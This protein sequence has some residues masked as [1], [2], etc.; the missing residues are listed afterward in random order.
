ML[1]AFKEEIVI[2]TIYIKPN[3]KLH[4]IKTHFQEI[5]RFIQYEYSVKKLII[6]GD[7]NVHVLD[8]QNSKLLTILQNF[9][10]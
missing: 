3:V 9:G 2:I 10:L 4:E 1:K 8:L 5:L 6:G 7:F